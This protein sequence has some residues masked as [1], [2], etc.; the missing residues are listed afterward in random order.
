MPLVTDTSR[1]VKRIDVLGGGKRI[2]LHTGFFQRDTT[3]RGLE[4]P[5]SDL[6]LKRSMF[7][8]QGPN[9][10]ISSSGTYTQLLRKNQ[11]IGYLIDRQGSFLSSPRVMDELFYVNKD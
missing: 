11:M 2:A 3:K 10:A 8:G 5:L 4:I 1:V 7:T 9:E 6:T